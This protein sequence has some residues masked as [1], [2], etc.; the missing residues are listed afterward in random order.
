MP[1]TPAVTANIGSLAQQTYGAPGSPYLQPLAPSN[2]TD[3]NQP[4]VSQYPQNPYDAAAPPSSA[5]GPVPWSGGQTYG[6]LWC[7]G[8]SDVLGS[9]SRPNYSAGSPIKQH[10]W[11]C[12]WWSYDEPG[13]VAYESRS[14]PGPQGKLN[15]QCHQLCIGLLLW[16]AVSLMT[17]CPCISASHKCIFVSC[18]KYEL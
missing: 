5:Y 12:K 11:K 1:F 7:F 3:Y 6:Q 18:R 13:Q 9:G 17:N 15:G 4:P 10:Q 16:A 14:S 8:T 2:G